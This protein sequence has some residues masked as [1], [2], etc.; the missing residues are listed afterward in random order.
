MSGNTGRY[1]DIVKHAVRTVMH[2]LGAGDRLAIVAFDSYAE[3]AFALG[4]MTEVPLATAQSRKSPTR[5]VRQHRE[6]AKAPGLPGCLSLSRFVRTPS[7]RLHTR[8]I[9]LFPEKNSFVLGTPTPA[10][11]PADTYAHAHSPS[12]HICAHMCTHQ[13]T[14]ISSSITL[15]TTITG[16]KSGTPPR[17]ADRAL[18]A[19]AHRAAIPR[20]ARYPGKRKTV[21]RDAKKNLTDYSFFFT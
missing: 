4:E 15:G 19:T 2:T 14:R 17:L 21:A 11:P 18:P 20:E 9:L 7:L 12:R 8:K 3:T 1:L 5:D 13:R 10:A 16:I 6:V